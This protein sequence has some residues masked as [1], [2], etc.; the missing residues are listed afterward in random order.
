MTKIY[1]LD[2]IKG[3]IQ[4]L[5]LSATIE[6]GFMAYSKGEVVVPPVGEL[7]FDT[8]PGDTHIKYGYL[9]NTS[10]Y[11]IKI[12]SGFYEN[13]EL[14]LPSRVRAIGILGTG[15]QELGPLHLPGPRTTRSAW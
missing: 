14:G 3:V 1:T 2:Q 13:P 4:T 7:V 12:A 8:P 6:E 15:I 5:E 10:F 9:K 11:V